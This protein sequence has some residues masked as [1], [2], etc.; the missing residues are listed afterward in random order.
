MKK[1]VLLVSALTLVAAPALAKNGMSVFK[2]YQ[3]AEKKA[4]TALDPIE[5]T[6]DVVMTE[7]GYTMKTRIVF[8]KKGDKTR[9]ETE[10]VERRRHHESG[11]SV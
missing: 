7:D 10:L 9:V 3:A 8:Y 5:M 1:I 2:A 6:Q 11:E 4:E